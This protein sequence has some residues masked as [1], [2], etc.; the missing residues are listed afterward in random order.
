LGAA[1]GDRDVY[2]YCLADPVNLVDP[3]GMQFEFGTNSEVSKEEKNRQ[4]GEE[5]E[6]GFGSSTDWV[7]DEYRNLDTGIVTQFARWMTGKLIEM[8]PEAFGPKNPGQGT[9][10]PRS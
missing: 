5:G 10:G 1:G 9:T 8:N 3:S 6:G 2:R 7:E 4:R